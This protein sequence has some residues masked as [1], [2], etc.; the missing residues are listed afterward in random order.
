MSVNRRR[1]DRERERKEV[2]MKVCEWR[3]DPDPDFTVW[4]TSCDE[5]FQFEADG[6]TENKFKFCPYCGDTL[7]VRRFA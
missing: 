3:L 5:M 4:E 6:P 1:N 2:Q 7:K